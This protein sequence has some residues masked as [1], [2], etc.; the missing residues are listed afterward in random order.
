MI[1][2]ISLR[3]TYP[4]TSR[5][6]C[7]ITLAIDS[8]SE[9]WVG[10]LS[11][12]FHDSS[13]L[14]AAHDTDT[15][16]G[17]HPEE[18]RAVCAAAHAIVSRTVAAADDNGELGHVGAGD[19]SHKLGAV[20]GD[21]LT[22]GSRADHEARNVLQ[23]DERDTTLRAKLN[24]VGT[25][26]GGRGK[27]NTV[28]GDDANLLTV[29]F[30]EASH[31]GRAVVSLEF[32][33]F[34]AVD[35]ACN[36]LANWH[37]LAKVGGSN[38]EE[39]LGVVERLREGLG[40]CLRSGGAFGPVQVADTAPGE[41]DSV[42]VVNSEVVGDTRD[43]RVH[44]TATKV[45]VADDLAGGGL[46]QGRTSKENM[47]LFLNNNALITHGGDIGTASCTGAHD[48]G[49]LGNALGAHAGLVIEDATKV[50]AVGEDVSLVRQV[51]TTAV[52]KVNATTDAASVSAIE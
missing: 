30:S 34:G 45:L 22:L 48:D 47:A 44:F 15:S 14:L 20:L 46:D 6:E 33:K 18:P 43:R 32:G 4:K 31:Q 26:H 17:P 11:N 23:E 10:L 13:Q 5:R 7:C 40:W 25:L 42:G 49:D 3:K 29:D 38:A 27:E 50:V 9:F 2:V 41:N 16:V 52:D 19:S 35:D 37:G 12:G 36:N 8:C 51:G 1:A 24:K 28:V 21:T 39:L